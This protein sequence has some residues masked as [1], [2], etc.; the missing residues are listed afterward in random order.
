MFTGIKRLL[1][2]HNNK[3]PLL[4][5]EEELK[6][7]EPDIEYEEEEEEEILYIDLTSEPVRRLTNAT[8]VEEIKKEIEIEEKEKKEDIFKNI[9]DYEDIKKILNSM[10]YNNIGNNESTTT[11]SIL[12]DGPAGT[13]KS[14]MLKCI[15]SAF[16]YES[17]YID[18]SRMTKAGLFG[19]LKEYSENNN[20]VNL[21]YLLIDELD[22]LDYG[23]QEA[24]LTLIEDHRIVQTQKNGTFTLEFPEL[25]VIS[26]SNDRDNINEALLTRFFSIHIKKY[27]DKQV[28]EI[29]RRELTKYRFL[30]KEVIEYIILRVLE[31][32]KKSKIRFAKQLAK[33]CKNS[34]SMV[35][36]LMNNS[37]MEEDEDE[38]EEY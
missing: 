5:D 24:L 4:Y 2:N 11:V 13:G 28:E 22:K 36:I 7:F 3:Y 10:L 9:V 37:T 14:L 23:D 27:T 25:R 21:K 18:G 31:S 15:N 35:D 38:K 30:D 8:I 34:K 29:A 26:A 16:P 6:R 1:F 19:L 17:R 33:L 20:G 32:R 12:L